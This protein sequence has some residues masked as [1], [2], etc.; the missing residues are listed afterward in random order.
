MAIKPVANL[1]VDNPDADGRIEKHG[2]AYPYDFKRRRESEAGRASWQDDSFVGGWDLDNCD[3]I[4]PLNALTLRGYA[5]KA[6][7]GLSFWSIVSGTGYWREE[8]IAG[9]PAVKWLAF[10]D[11]RADKEG[12]LRSDGDYTPRLCLWV[13]RFA[14]PPDQSPDYYESLEIILAGE[15]TWGE[16]QISYAIQFPL[17]SEIE[18]YKYPVLQRGTWKYVDPPG[19]WQ[20]T[21]KKVDEWRRPSALSNALKD[22]VAYQHIWIQE[23][24][25]ILLIGVPGVEDV[26]EYDPR[27]GALRPQTGRV[28]VKLRGFAGM[29]NL[30]QIQYPQGSSSGDPP[31][32]EA[33]A[34][35]HGWL[36]LPSWM[37]RTEEEPQ[38]NVVEGKNSEGSVAVTYEFIPG[39]HQYR[40]IVKLT[41]DPTS[42]GTPVVYGIHRYITPIFAD[43]RSEPVETDSGADEDGKPDTHGQLIEL[44]WTR[45]W[46]RDWRF[47]A[48]LRDPEHYWVDKLKAQCKVTVEVG[49]DTAADTQIMVGYLDDPAKDIE[50]GEIEEQLV[51][52]GRDYIMA[53]LAEKKFAAWFCPPEGWKMRE[54][55]TEALKRAGV[56]EALIEVAAEDTPY[57]VPVRRRGESAFRIGRDTPLVRMLDEVLKTHKNMTTGD[58][59]P[60]FLGIS[61]AGKITIGPEPTYSTPDYTLDDD[62]QSKDDWIE[63]IQATTDDDFRNYVAVF[64]DDDPARLEGGVAIHEPSHKTPEDAAFTG[65]DLWHVRVEPG[66]PEDEKKADRLL[67]HYLRATR[68][69]EWRTNMKPALGP[70]SFVQ[71]DIDNLRLPAGSIFRIMEDH[72]SIYP[73]RGEAR[74]TLIG[75]F[76]Q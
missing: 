73:D 34:I 28:Q 43:A 61:A 14:P 26:W 50:A 68:K 36:Q 18:G 66:A 25:G 46:P 67:T 19:E 72:G 9:K 10:T 55:V 76:E 71:V 37:N 12:E 2:F 74:H 13:R 42:L 49:W 52:T 41:R 30:Q 20:V 62:T 15:S 38:Y 24:D 65:E 33:W 60:W 63:W 59:E 35:P 70:G 3:I 22:D 64:A 4:L 44:S 58:A 11:A 6:D 8:T 56:R 54:W 29:F 16:D 57:E 51:I 31:A 48:V 53:R 39:T 47:R 40:P 17:H 21:W 7:M 45:R 27:D 5:V 1:I 69:I 75:V 32:T 23:L